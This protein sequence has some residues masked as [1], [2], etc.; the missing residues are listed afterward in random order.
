MFGPG[1]LL[2]GGKGKLEYI[3]YASSSSTIAN[4]TI[5][6]P[7]PAGA[8]AGDLV[9]VVAGATASAFGLTVSGFSHPLQVTSP[10]VLSMAWR[11]LDGSEGS[12][13]TVSRSGGAQRLLAQALLFRN[14]AFDA[15]GSIVTLAGNGSVV[16][17][18][19]TAVGG[20]LIGAVFGVTD[21]SR[22]W[23][24]PSGM[25]AVSPILWNNDFPM[26][27]F[28]QGVAAGATGNRTTT[29]SGG[30]NSNYGWLGAI[31]RA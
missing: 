23:S 8:R 15:V 19:I 5:T 4:N 2:L 31:K 12:T 14:A 29:A 10:I 22:A 28:L 24:V 20:Y 26:R 11:L 25:T 30:V 13:F 27:L 7:K 3:G 9:V 16:L 21:A 18:G 17:P 6:V 1:K